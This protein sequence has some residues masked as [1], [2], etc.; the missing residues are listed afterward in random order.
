MSPKAIAPKL[1]L[2]SGHR[3]CG[4]ETGRHPQ[5]PHHEAGTYKVTRQPPQDRLLGTQN[6]LGPY[7]QEL[8]NG[9]FG[10]THEGNRGIPHA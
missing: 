9:H 5:N 7:L 2:Q 4:V 8:G 1:T 6:T 3:V 10:I